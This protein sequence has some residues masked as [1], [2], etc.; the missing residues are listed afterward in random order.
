MADVFEKLVMP[1]F[2]QLQIKAKLRQSAL[3]TNTGKKTH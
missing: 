2:T 1:D 3:K